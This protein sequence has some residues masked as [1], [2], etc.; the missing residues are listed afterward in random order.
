MVLPKV[1]S[2]DCRARWELPAVDEVLQRDRSLR[3]RNMLR[4]DNG[5]RRPER[6]AV[7]RSGGRL[8]K[9]NGCGKVEDGSYSAEALAKV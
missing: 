3:W 5:W 6:L 9:F 8:R 2:L 1:L 7:S 4:G